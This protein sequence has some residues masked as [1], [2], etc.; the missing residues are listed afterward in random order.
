MNPMVSVVA[1][2]GSALPSKEITQD[3]DV[4]LVVGKSLG[5]LVVWDTICHDNKVAFFAAVS[6]GT[7]A[8]FFTDLGEHSYQGHVSTNQ[9]L[10]YPSPVTYL[11]VN[12][13]MAGYMAS[14]KTGSLSS[15]LLWPYFSLVLLVSKVL[16]NEKSVQIDKVL[17]WSSSDKIEE[18]FC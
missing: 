3:Y 2:S 13:Y 14:I 15:G 17:V 7:Q 4:V 1:R 10:L 11:G 9:S 6:R 5:S 16:F 18:L 12:F 8:F